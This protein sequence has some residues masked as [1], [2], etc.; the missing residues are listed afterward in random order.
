MKKFLFVLMLAVAPVSQHA[1]AAGEL[2]NI[3]AQIKKTERQNQKLAQQVNTSDKE[4]ESTKR[5]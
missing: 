2:A 1:H 3:Q 5:N 4:I